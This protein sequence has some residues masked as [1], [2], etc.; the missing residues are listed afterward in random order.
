MCKHKYKLTETDEVF[1]THCESCGDIGTVTQ[2]RT[3][4]DGRIYPMYP[5]YP[6]N[7]TYPWYPGWDLSGFI[8]IPCG[9]S[10]SDSDLAETTTT[11][12]I[13]K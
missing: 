13:E 9:T 8:A 12:K 2:K 5:I 3:Y 1:I 7:P 10:S 11:T 4:E 6:L